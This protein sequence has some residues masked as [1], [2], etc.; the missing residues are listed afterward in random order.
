MKKRIAGFKSFVVWV[1]L[2]SSSVQTLAPL[3]IMP[4]Q[5]MNAYNK[6]Q[7]LKFVQESTNSFL[8]SILIP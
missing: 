3:T 2:M 6:N 4:P 7:L 5:H 8:G 1:E